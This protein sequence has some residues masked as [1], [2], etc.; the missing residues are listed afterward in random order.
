[1][2]WKFRLAA[3]INKPKPKS[4]WRNTITGCPVSSILFYLYG[5]VFAFLS[6]FVDTCRQGGQRSFLKQ[7]ASLTGGQSIK[8]FFPNGIKRTKPSIQLTR[9]LTASRAHWCQNNR[10]CAAY[11]QNIMLCHLPVRW[12]ISVGLALSDFRINDPVWVFHHSHTHTHT[13]YLSISLIHMHTHHINVTYKCDKSQTHIHTQMTD[14]SIRVRETHVTNIQYGA[15]VCDPIC[16]SC[17]DGWGWYERCVKS[18]IT[19]SSPSEKPFGRTG[20]VSH[21]SVIFLLCRWAVEH[22]TLGKGL[23]IWG[24]I[25][26]KL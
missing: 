26:I 10:F 3:V 7:T 22:V 5:S 4:V 6:S 14:G 11:F 21:I 25:R 9:R 20:S 13:H 8:V 24:L 18:C 15:A 16:V 19:Q 17:H 12:I 2:I 1:M 23:K